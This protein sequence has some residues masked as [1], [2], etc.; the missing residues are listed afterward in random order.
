MYVYE[1]KTYACALLSLEAGSVMNLELRRWPM[2]PR[3]PP[4][5]SAGVKG[6]CIALPNSLGARDL[7]S[8]CH[9]YLCSKHSHPQGHL[10]AAALSFCVWL[11]TLNIIS[12]GSTP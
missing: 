12:S 6:V 11:I 7:N 8:H 10:P 2:R 3:D 1:S 5:L 9:A 4:L